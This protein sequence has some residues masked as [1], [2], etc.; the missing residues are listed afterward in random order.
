MG[1][2]RSRFLM[3]LLTALKLVWRSFVAHVHKP[4]CVELLDFKVLNL[5]FE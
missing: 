5:D 4:A 2:M 3:P 1:I